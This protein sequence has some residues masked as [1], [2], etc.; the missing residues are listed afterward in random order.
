MSHRMVLRDALALRR[1]GRLYE[2][3]DTELEDQFHGS[4]DRFSLIA[5]AMAGR[6]RILDIGSGRGLLLALLALRGHECHAVDYCD[7]R[8]QF[9]AAARTVAFR[10]CNVEVEPLPYPDG[11]FDGITCCQVLEHFS[12]SHLPAVREMHR[13][14]KPGGLLEIDVPNVACWRNRWR[15]LRGK[16]ITWDYRTH[17]LHAEPVLAHGRSFYPVRH[18]REFTCDEL[19]MLLSE[20]GFAAPRV[21]FLKSRRVRP[22][23]ARVLSLGSG[24]RDALPGLRKSLIA[25]AV[26]D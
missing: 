3:T 23:V 17:Y 18:N 9:P 24:L 1:S 5:A 11:Y 19:R 10:Q 13:V 8:D 20:A 21:D 25:F 22:G 6:A 26:K 16:N 7:R 4:V 2:R 15:L 14:L 12:H